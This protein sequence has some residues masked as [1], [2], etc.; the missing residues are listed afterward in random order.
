MAEL[1]AN[2]LMDSVPDTDSDTEEAAPTCP[3]VA[4]PEVRVCEERSDKTS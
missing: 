3:P 2:P 1:P 4:P